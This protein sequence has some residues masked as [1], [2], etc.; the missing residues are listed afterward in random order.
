MGDGTVTG[1]NA[2]VTWLVA[3]DP[4]AAGAPFPSLRG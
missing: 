3:D 4:I 1:D 2:P